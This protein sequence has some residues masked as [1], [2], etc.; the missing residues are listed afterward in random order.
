MNQFNVNQF[1]YQ[2]NVNLQIDWR[3]Q[4]S[5]VYLWPAL[6]SWLDVHLWR[7]TWRRSLRAA[8]GCLAARRGA[9]GSPAA[10]RGCLV[11]LLSALRGGWFPKGQRMTIGTD[12]PNVW[13]KLAVLGSLQS[14]Y[15]VFRFVQV[16][17]E[18]NPTQNWPNIKVL[19]PIFPKRNTHNIHM[20]PSLHVWE[21]CQVQHIVVPPHLAPSHPAQAEKVLGVRY[22]LQIW[23]S[24]HKK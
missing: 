3:P 13:L 19:G 5:K 20:L 15:V 18:E 10:A 1:N 22:V 24:K 12:F 21:I 17:F 7:R 6:G 4:L 2:T 14:F 23:H 16:E 11:Y 9:D 8:L